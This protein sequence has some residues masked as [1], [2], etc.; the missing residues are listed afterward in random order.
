[1]ETLSGWHHFY[2]GIVLAMLGFVLLWAPRHWLA[3]VGI[4]ICLLGLIIMIDDAFQ[5]AMERFYM[6]GY[7][8]PLKKVFLACDQICPL[9]GKVTSFVDDLF[10]GKNP[11]R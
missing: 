5:H 1:M 6:A 2:V 9:I 10:R 11:L 8:S 4:A 3:V 7:D